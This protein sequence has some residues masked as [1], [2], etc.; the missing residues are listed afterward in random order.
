MQTIGERLE[1]ARKRKGISIREA[2]EATKI[3][4]DYLHKFESN[5]FDIR[6]PE[7][8]VRGFLRTYASFLKLPAEKIAGDYAGLG[9]TGETKSSRSLNR[10]NFGRMELS[11]ATRG[12]GEAA[13][14]ESPAAPAPSA[15]QADSQR[16]PATFRPPAPDRGSPLDTKLILKLG[17]LV[18]AG[19]TL[20]VLLIWGI[21]AMVSAPAPKAP[22]QAER[23]AATPTP[24]PAEGATLTLVAAQP[25]RLKVVRQADGVELFQGQ[26]EAGT[27]KDFP[28]VPLHVTSTALEHLSIEHKGKTWPTGHTGY[29][30]ISLDF[31]KV[32]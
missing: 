5:Q 32:K 30:R 6:L 1:E 20:L 25:M 16:N 27:R 23:P 11:V 2:A 9:L 29:F 8:Y 14:T 13:R 4:G 3:R 22:A 17:G 21:S 15:P 19:L 24:A 26:I 10:E 28:N 12:P 18:I 7:I 31:T